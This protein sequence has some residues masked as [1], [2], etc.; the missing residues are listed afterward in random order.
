MTK[1]IYPKLESL[2]YCSGFFFPYGVTPGKALAYFIFF[3]DKMW[4]NMPGNTRLLQGSNELN[5]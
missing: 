4:K 1:A 3:M 2:I 5:T